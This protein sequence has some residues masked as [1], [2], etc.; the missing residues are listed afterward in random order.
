MKPTPYEILIAYRVIKGNTDGCIEAGDLIYFFEDGCLVCSEV[1]F[2][3][4]E[5]LSAE[6]LDF[7]A[8]P[9]E[10]HFDYSD[11]FAERLLDIER[12]Q[13]AIQRQKDQSKLK[14]IK[15]K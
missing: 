11:R 13:Q 12:V 9:D 10:R 15:E 6:I 7:E 14:K 5:E 2:L 8:V 4:S 1:G 3:P